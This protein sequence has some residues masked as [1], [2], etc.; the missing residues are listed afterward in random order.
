MFEKYI[1]YSNINLLS[2][3]V[4]CEEERRKRSEMKKIRVDKTNL[5]RSSLAHFTLF[6]V[7]D[8]V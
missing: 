2:S 3:Y 8:S 5:R 4:F 7:S 6:V 1:D